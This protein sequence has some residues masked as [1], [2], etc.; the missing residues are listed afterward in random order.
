MNASPEKI[1][2]DIAR[3]A[4]FSAAGIASIS[5]LNESNDIF[6][7]W[8]RE[9]KS[10]GMRYLGSNAPT[11]RDPGRLLPGARSVISVAL[12]YHV[13]EEAGAGETLEAAGRFS[14]YARRGDYH[15]VMGRMLRSLQKRMEEI[16]PGVATVACVD[17]K[18]VAERTF[19]L[20]A[21]IGWL[22]KNGCVISPEYGSWIFL[23]EIMTDMELEPD[24]PLESLCGDCNLCIESCPTS[25]IEQPSLLDAGKCI[26]Y[27]TIENKGQIPERFHRGMGNRVFGCDT[28]QTV[29]PYNTRPRESSVF[30]AIGQAPI[31]SLGLERLVSVSDEE[32]R[33]L[34]AGSIIRRCKAEGM[35]RNARIALDNV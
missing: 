22:G 33:A 30:R 26:S 13:P 16:F 14:L 18:P 21:G 2:K 12:D 6:E 25:A 15:V 32:F 31:V 17:T 7:G 19:A 27:L 3:A 20:K 5:A 8:I 35:R 9:G 29:C 10:A 24:S 23:G 1:I 4:G 28:C 34:T 11:R